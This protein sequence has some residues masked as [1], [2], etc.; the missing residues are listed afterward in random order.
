MISLEHHCPF[1]FHCILDCQLRN[2]SFCLTAFQIL[3]LFHMV[4]IILINISVEVQSSFPDYISDFFYKF[5]KIFLIY[6]YYFWILDHPVFLKILP[7]IGF[8]INSFEYI[9]NIKC[10]KEEL[11]EELQVFLFLNWN[12]WL[13][14][15][16][17]LINSL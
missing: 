6:I 12:F 2:I 16:F 9:C 13:H 11:L 10:N 15:V 3:L 5:L 7:S 17:F 4:K 8:S 14:N 1:A